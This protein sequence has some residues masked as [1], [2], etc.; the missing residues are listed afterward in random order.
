MQDQCL[1][2]LKSELTSGRF[3]AAQLFVAHRGTVV[4]DIAVGESMPGTPVSTDSYFNL[5]CATKPVLAMIAARCLEAHG[6]DETAQV[7]RIL[8]IG[9]NPLTVADLCSHQAG[10]RSPDAFS[11]HIVSPADREK[12]LDPAV[13]LAASDPSK[14]EY[15]EIAAWHLLMCV[16]EYLEGRP[17]ASV[18]EEDL[19]ILC[20]NDIWFSAEPDLERVDDIGCYLDLSTRLPLLHDRVQRFH[21]PPPPAA[22]GGFASMSGLGRWYQSLLRAIQGDEVPGL[23]SS[24]T[25]NRWVRTRRTGQYDP[26]LRYTS[27]FGLGFMSQLSTHRFGERP[28]TEAV[29]HSGFLGNSFGIVDP[30][31]DLVV[32]SFQNGILGDP[33]KN[34]ERSRPA[35]VSWIYDTLGISSPGDHK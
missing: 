13:L 16:V 27:D 28:S 32:A 30:V 10:L 24:A 2:R 29:G 26:V 4:C 9:S 22:E 11:Y 19:A 8:D 6:L 14:V 3:G 25:V 12:L 31:H 33:L 15:S 20:D 5:H 1:A 21:S 34:V 23:P 17:A 18:V 35:L 7:A